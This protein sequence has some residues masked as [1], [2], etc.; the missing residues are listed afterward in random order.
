MTV[1]GLTGPSGGGK[2]AVLQYLRAKGATCIDADEVYH[3]VLQTDTALV[4]AIAAQF[5]SA[6]T[7]GTLDRK[8]L[9]RCVF[10][11]SEAL[12]ALEAVTHPAVLSAIDNQLRQH[13]KDGVAFVAVEAIALHRSRLY[14]LCD[15]TIT[16]TAPL[17][18]LAQRIMARDGISEAYAAARLAAQTQMTFHPAQYQIDNLG[19]K[20]ELYRKIDT[21]L[22]TQAITF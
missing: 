6:V 1:W 15:T 16:V 2:S 7:Q 19:D 10:A 21:I 13:A 22:T 11:S 3:A 5:P 14:E 12:V 9:G 20:D 18:L 8:A 4:A 17:S